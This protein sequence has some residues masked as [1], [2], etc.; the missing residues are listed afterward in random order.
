MGVKDFEKLKPEYAEFA[1][2]S[3]NPPAI[4]TAQ[5]EIEEVPF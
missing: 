2:M 5:T 3:A 4:E 1:K